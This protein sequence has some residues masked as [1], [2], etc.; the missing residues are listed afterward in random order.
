MGSATREKATP[1]GE[2]KTLQ[3]I[4]PQGERHGYSGIHKYHI[5]NSTTS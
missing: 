4:S 3:D 2:I 1:L 5:S